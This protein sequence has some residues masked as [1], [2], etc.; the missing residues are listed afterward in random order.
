MKAI[1]TIV[2]GA[3]LIALLAGCKSQEERDEDR[4]VLLLS[5]YNVESLS[6][7]IEMLP[8][9]HPK[10]QIDFVPYE[11]RAAYLS[12]D[13]LDLAL[14]D[15]NT[16]LARSKHYLAYALRGAVYAWMGEYDKA[17][18]DA[19]A[20]IAAKPNS[21][22]PYDVRGSVYSAREEYAQAIREFTTAIENYGKLD[23]SPEEFSLRYRTLR[24]REPDWVANTYLQR[25]IAYVYSGA[26]DKAL[27]DLDAALAMHHVLW[28]IN[29]AWVY[30]YRGA[31]LQGLGRKKEAIEAYKEFLKNPR[32]LKSEVERAKWTIE[33]LER[34]LGTGGT[35]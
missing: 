24:I 20:A 30:F 33:A 26:Y 19:D 14:A 17:M 4:F 23:E 29:T 21:A 3:G 10:D 32:D 34:E 12:G 27:A 8:K 5:Y 7:A 25:G 1:V 11:K 9:L 35:P 31:A 16:A 13:R 18:A 6:E 22:L 15:C 28:C 2:L